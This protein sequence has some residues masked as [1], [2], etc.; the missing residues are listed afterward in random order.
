MSGVALPLSLLMTQG[1]D[2]LMITTVPV[3]P[4]C[5]YSPHAVMNPEALS[6]S[7]SKENYFE[8]QEVASFSRYISIY[9]ACI[10]GNYE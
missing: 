8:V 7:Q 1:C 3:M 9:I 5:F 10:R 2:Y 4:Y 6:K